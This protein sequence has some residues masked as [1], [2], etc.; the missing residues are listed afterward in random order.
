MKF[1][2][3]CS[4][5]MKLALLLLFIACSSPALLQ[6]GLRIEAGRLVES[7][8]TPFVMRG[9]NV[10]H[11]WFPKQTRSSLFAI[12]KAGFNSARLV[13]SSG[14]RWKE[15]SR[16][17]LENI[18]KWCHELGLL[19]IVEVHDTTGHGQ[20]EEQGSVTLTDVLPFWRQHASLF[21]GTEDWVI[22]N[23]GNEPF[24]NV[25]KPSPWLAEQMATVSAL[26]SFGYKNV[27]MLDADNYGQ[28]WKRTTRDAA[29]ELI[30]LD[31]QLIFS[32]HMYEVYGEARKVEAYFRSFLEHGLPLVVGEFAAS[33][34][35]K[36]VAH[37]AIM[38]KAQRDGIG[39]LAWSWHGN[40]SALKDLDVSLGF[41]AEGLSPWGKVLVHGKNGI[42]ATSKILG[43]FNKP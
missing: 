17:E 3:R 21:E 27:L 38:A 22:V 35:G 39:Y 43:H 33:H 31:T 36:P 40:H 23:M 26:R 16:G 25:I 18:L 30:K 42:Q 2:S 8:G 9:V 28:D 4:H 24:G 1:K 37:K 15:T 13:C 11:A 14:H 6:A 10:A 34:Y 20:P 7:D 32:V 5:F 29:L 19:C 41:G 12:A